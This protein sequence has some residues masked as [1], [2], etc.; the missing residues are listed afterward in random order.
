[1]DQYLTTLEM[2]DILTDGDMSY[3]EY[4][5]YLVPDEK[6][7]L[8]PPKAISICKK[9]T[10]GFIIKRKKYVKLTKAQRNY[11]KSIFKIDPNPTKYDDILKAL[12]SRGYIGQNLIKKKNIY[13]FFKNQRHRVRV[14]KNPEL[15]IT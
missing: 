13:A 6:F 15:K 11:L 2:Y 7:T 12:I 10:F 9:K 5:N 1:M 3:K 14:K 8:T 4:I